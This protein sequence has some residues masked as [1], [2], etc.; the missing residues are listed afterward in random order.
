M[1]LRSSKPVRSSGRVRRSLSAGRRH[2][3]RL[4]GLLV[5]PAIVVALLALLIPMG[6]GSS[7]GAVIAIGFA[8]L[9][10]ALVTFGIETT[11]TG[12]LTL[13]FILAPMNNVRP[14]A[15][16]TFVTA[17]DVFL[18]FGVGALI[19]ILMTRGFQ[20]QA[21]YLIGASGI[22]AMGMLTSAMAPAVGASLNGLTRLVIGALALPIVFMLWRPG[23]H[24]LYLFAGSYVVGVSISVA[25]GLISGIRSV[26]GRYAGY[27]QHPNILGIVSMLGLALIP[28]LYNEL[29]SRLRWL[30]LAGAA[31]AA[32]GVWFSGSRAALLAVIAC[33][34][35][36]L[37]L[38]RSIEHA[39]IFSGLAIVPLYLIGQVL[40]SPIVSTSNPI[41]RLAGGGSASYSDTEREQLA[42]AALDRFLAHPVLGSGYE[43]A[44]EAHN[45]FL[46][47]AAAGGLIGLAFYLLVLVATVRQPLVIG[48]RYRLLAVPALGY[49]LM[50]PL[51]P[52]IWDRYIWCVLALPFLIPR[53][54]PS[55]E[56]EPIEAKATVELD[57]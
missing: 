42:S 28:F 4:L 38:S 30:A 50:G 43:G 3:S 40:T 8:V 21:P 54:D 15:S 39:L 16:V 49:A 53:P 32:G 17:S 7:D 36:Y 52:L 9:L 19:P 46:Q 56:D 47:V 5:P 48:A 6:T 45:V 1:S 31:G 22:L 10:V 27:T 44:A 33:L 20:R 41:A 24:V 18:F 2:S 34:G 11:A 29:P 14:V 26:D 51:T 37:L 25:Y 13:G 35:I 57:R 12:L 55:G 23:R